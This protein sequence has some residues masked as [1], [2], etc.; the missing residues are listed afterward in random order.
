MA[1]MDPAPRCA[2]KVQVAPSLV[3][4]HSSHSSVKSSKPPIRWRVMEPP[5]VLR[6]PNSARPRQ[7]ELPVFVVRSEFCTVYPR[8]FLARAYLSI[9]RFLVPPEL[10]RSGRMIE[11]IPSC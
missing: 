10:N 5:L 6:Y 11:W 8:I 9:H 3:L 2:M 4:Y 7:V 1:L